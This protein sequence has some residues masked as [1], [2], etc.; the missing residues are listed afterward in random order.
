MFVAFFHELKTAGV[1][2]TLRE[3]LTLMEAMEKDLAG[4]RVEDFYYLAR[5]A[6]VKDERNLDKFDRVFG[7]VF[8]GLELMSEAL[9]AEIP[10][11][12][13][14]KLAEKY[15]T[16]E[17]KKQIEAIGGLDKLLELLRQRMREQKGRHQG[18]KKWIGTGGTS[19]FGA[20]GYNP[21]GVRIGQDENR[22]FR[23]VKVWDRRD[24]KDLD[25]QV[26]LGTRNIK[27]ALRRLRRF[28]RTG[29]PEELDLDGT[30]KGSAH[31][32][33]LDILMRP[34]RHNAVKVLLFF[35]VGGSM[36]W[37]VKATEELFSA[38]RSEFKHME[39]FYFHNCLYERVWKENRRRFE[40]TTPTWDVLHTY[41]HDYKVIVVGDASMSPYEIMA[42][43]GSVEHF[44]E[45]TGASWMERVARTY[46]ACVWLNP[47]AEK[48]WDYTQSI[49]IMRQLMGGRMYPLTLDGLDKAMR[50]LVR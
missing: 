15:L 25:D 9:S 19:P 23:A 41:P 40:D 7:H 30:I 44:N 46:P 49:R 4:R 12:W 17:E 39:H 11:E 31:K 48:D 5:A 50:E 10:A 36:D 45:E 37:H 21:E 6:L 32:G 8:K 34:E 29:A 24:F 16:E 47:V 22:N 13:L 26:E 35:D 18:G 3:Y 33:Y 28:A 2:V 43:G 38:A 27:V 14:K 42:P 20:Y 1:P